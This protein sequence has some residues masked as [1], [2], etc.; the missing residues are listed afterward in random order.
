[1]LPYPC[2]TLRASS[3]L[4]IVP[5]GV[6]A[7]RVRLVDLARGILALLVERDR[8]VISI[9]GEVTGGRSLD[10]PFVSTTPTVLGILALEERS[11]ADDRVR[12]TDLLL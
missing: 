11:C 10:L 6:V 1:M 9:L 8:R 4:R 5:V 3:L 7:F 12:L 2:P